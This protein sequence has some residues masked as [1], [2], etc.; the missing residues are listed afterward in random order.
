MNTPQTK[1]KIVLYFTVVYCTVLG[2]Y[3]PVQEQDCTVLYC[4]EL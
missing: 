2:E 3:V 1:G 4:S